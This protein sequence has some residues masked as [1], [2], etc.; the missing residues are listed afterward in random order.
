MYYQPGKGL[1]TSAT[2]FE[3]ILKPWDGR[4][5]CV[6]E[7]RDGCNYVYPLFLEMLWRCSICTGT[8]KLMVTSSAVTNPGWG[9]GLAVHLLNDGKNMV[10]LPHGSIHLEQS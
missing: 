5:I 2:L 1:T 10:F 4:W 3:K 7:Y 6:R 9:S 8:L